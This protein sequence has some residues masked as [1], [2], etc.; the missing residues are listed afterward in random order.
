MESES[1]GEYDHVCRDKN[2]SY[3]SNNLATFSFQFETSMPHNQWLNFSNQ[4][5]MYMMFII[6]TKPLVISK[7]QTTRLYQ[8]TVSKKTDTNYFKVQN[9]MA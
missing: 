4:I 5:Y 9:F 7:Y 3:L 6:Y 8:L 1:M 2:I